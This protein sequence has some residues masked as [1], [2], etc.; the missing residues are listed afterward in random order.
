MKKPTLFKGRWQAM[1]Y[2]SRY[3][4]KMEWYTTEITPPPDCVYVYVDMGSAKDIAFRVKG[5]WFS[6][7]DPEIQN[8]VLLWTPLPDRDDELFKQR[9]KKMEE[10]E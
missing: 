3:A 10:E 9:I 7:T 6:A 5:H 8:A 4:D 1:Q 2:L